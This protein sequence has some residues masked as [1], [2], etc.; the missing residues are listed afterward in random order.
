MKISKRLNTIAD[1]VPVHSKVID[2]GCDHGLLSIYLDLEKKCKVIATDVNINALNMAKI[3][4]KKYNVSNV[5]TILTDGLD[6]IDISKDDYIIIAGMGTTTIKHILS[7]KTLSDNL[8]ISSNNQW[9]EL[10]KYVTSLGY[11]ILDERF[12]VDQKKSYVIIQ[13]KK[14]KK[15]YSKLDLKYGPILKKDTNYLIYELEKLFKVK[16][17]IKDTKLIVKF[18]NWKEI[19]VVNKLIKKGK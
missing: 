7:N 17:K 8:I 10:R 5:E 15:N 16:E 4:V 2:V 6:G 12:V 18:K 19:R 14:G 13:F 9:L 1:L 11:I 3:N